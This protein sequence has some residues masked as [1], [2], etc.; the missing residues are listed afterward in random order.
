M[1]VIGMFTHLMTISGADLV[2]GSLVERF[3]KNVPEK[4]KETS[5]FLILFLVAAAFSAF[6]QNVSVAMAML[7]AVYGISRTS[8]ISRSKMILFLIYATTLGGA[9]TLIGTPTNVFASGALE[10]VGLAPL[11]FFD[12]AWVAVPILILGG[13]Y[14][15]IFH[16]RCPGYDDYD[17]EDAPE[18]TVDSPRKARQRTWT[19]AGFILFVLL[20]IANSLIKSSGVRFAAYIIAFGVFAVMYLTKVFSWKEIIHGYPYEN[21][22]FTAGILLAIRIVT[23]TNLGEA[24]G[25]LV[26]SVVGESSNLYVITAVLFIATAIVTQFMNN[27]ACAGALAPIGIAIANSMGANPQAIVLTIAIGAGCSYLTPMAS[28]TNQ[29]MVAFTRLKFQDFAKFGWPLVIISFVCCVFIL[30]QVFPFF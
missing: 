3:T 20:L 28:G 23:T 11:G 30:P 10:E 7:P 1:M 29:T 26:I 21:V 18:D 24:F 15:V 4:R 9:V 8:R 5:I 17:D 22:I 2:I 27:M 6:L 14:M 16:K 19:F 12:F 25:N 13:A